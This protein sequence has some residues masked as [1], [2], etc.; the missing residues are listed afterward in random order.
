MFSKHFGEAWKLGNKTFQYLLLKILVL[1]QKFLV[2][3]TVFVIKK[4]LTIWAGTI[5]FKKLKKLSA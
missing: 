5:K 4:R 1:S 3:D 2:L